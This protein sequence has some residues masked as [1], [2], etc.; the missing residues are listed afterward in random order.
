MFSLLFAK[1]RSFE[2][3]YGIQRLREVG[4][5]ETEALRRLSNT[6]LCSDEL[7]KQLDH[8][9]YDYADPL[10]YMGQNEAFSASS[11]AIFQ[12][13]NSAK[14]SEKDFK[15]LATTIDSLTPALGLSA[16]QIVFYC[17]KPLAFFKNCFDEDKIT[18][19]TYQTFNRYAFASLNE[20]I[21]WAKGSNT[22]IY[23]AKVKLMPHECNQD[24]GVVGLICR[25]ETHQ[26]LSIYDKAEAAR[27]SRSSSASSSEIEMK[28]K[29]D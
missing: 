12:V 20:A 14:L 29:C 1:T 5:L 26:L 13:L 24:K 25:D 22:R 11:R 17:E 6:S 3:F 18:A 2:I 8:F 28:V 27:A 7:I 16:P 15:S 21:E 19:K 23:Q 10:F 4:L 9:G